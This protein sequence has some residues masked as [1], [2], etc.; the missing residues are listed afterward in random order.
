MGF[1]CSLAS[2]LWVSSIFVLMGPWS[3]LVWTHLPKRQGLWVG[4]VAGGG[5][6]PGSKD[7]P[8]W[9]TQGV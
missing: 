5:V 2:G 9:W 4:G 8:S 3:P 1:T 6:E 7:G